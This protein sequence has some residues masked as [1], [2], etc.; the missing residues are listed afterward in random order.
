[1]K[2]TEINSEKDF[3]AS[4]I[5]RELPDAYDKIIDMDRVQSIGE[6]VFI[7][8]PDIFERNLSNIIVTSVDN[9]QLN[10]KFGNWDFSIEQDGIIRELSEHG[11]IP[12]A[13][14]EPIFKDALNKGLYQVEISMEVEKRMN[15]SDLIDTMI[16]DAKDNMENLISEESQTRL[17]DDILL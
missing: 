8:A 7:S 14:L 16:H 3:V 5:V 12:K 2:R 13:E 17:P 1:M 9:K 15:G 4:R 11:D 6:A 10:F